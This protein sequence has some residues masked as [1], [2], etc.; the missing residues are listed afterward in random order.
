MKHRLC[1]SSLTNSPPS[2][3]QLYPQ[4][5]HLQIFPPNKLRPHVLQRVRPRK[6][7]QP[8]VGIDGSSAV[9]HA[10]HRLLMYQE[11]YHWQAQVYMIAK[12][13]WCTTSITFIFC[14]PEMKMLWNLP[15]LHM[16]LPSSKAVLPLLL[17]IWSCKGVVNTGQTLCE[18]LVVVRQLQLGSILA[19]AS[20]PEN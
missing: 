8:G 12:Q 7:Q 19:C 17:S 6:F 20:S 16:H 5:F 11:M 15:I 4:M 1:Y 18:T 3:T 2:I 14:W 10:W 9:P 13:K